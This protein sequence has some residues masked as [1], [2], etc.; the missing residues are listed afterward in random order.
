M[1]EHSYFLG[2]DEGAHR[3]NMQLFT[4]AMQFQIVFLHAVVFKII[5]GVPFKSKA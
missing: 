3:Y 1:R 4:V 2:N 5:G